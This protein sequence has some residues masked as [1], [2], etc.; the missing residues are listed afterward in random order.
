M[1]TRE[2][3][4][5]E[6]TVNLF[7]TALFIPIQK[8][9]KSSIEKVVIKLNKKRTKDGKGPIV[10]ST[11]KKWWKRFQVSFFLFKLTLNY[12][13]Q[14]GDTSLKRQFNDDCNLK[15]VGVRTSHACRISNHDSEWRS[16]AFN[17]RYLFE[18]NWATNQ[19]HI[20]VIDTF[21]GRT[22]QKHL[23]EFALFIFSI[24]CFYISTH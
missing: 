19:P 3:L 5:S 12:F 14:S 8:K 16:T 1:S 2:E 9:P 13:I 20:C 6:F 22:W 7:F 11:A 18:F 15:I 17:G 23:M 24:Q 4:L 10:L 21:H